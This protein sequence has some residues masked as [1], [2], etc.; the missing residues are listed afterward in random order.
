MIPKISHRYRWED[1]RAE[2]YRDSAGPAQRVLLF[3]KLMGLSAMVEGSEAFATAA[4][5]YSRLPDTHTHTHDCQLQDSPLIVRGTGLNFRLVAS[6]VVTLV[7]AKP[8]RVRG[9]LEGPT[10]R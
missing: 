4:F 9:E 8:L 1:N 7:F 5:G 6:F 3:A 2:V 10:G